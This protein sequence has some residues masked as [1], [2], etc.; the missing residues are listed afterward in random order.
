[1]ARVAEPLVIVGA[2]GFGRETADVVEAINASVRT[3]DLLGFVD[4]APSAINLERLRRRGYDWLG[5]VASVRGLSDRVRFVVGIGAPSVRRILAARLEDAS[6]RAATLV[7]PAATIGSEVTLGEGTIV[8]AGARITTNIEVGRHVHVNPNVTVGHDT[9]IE[10]FVS[11]N[12]A[13]SISGD[14][15]IGTGTL[16]GVGAVVLNQIGVGEGATVGGG[17]CVVREVPADLVVKGV[18]AR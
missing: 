2:G 9:V 15:T 16:I 18:P 13:C 14:C 7:H 4:D 1:M 8:C 12:P 11:L 5:D 10:D 17:A 6:L 3:W